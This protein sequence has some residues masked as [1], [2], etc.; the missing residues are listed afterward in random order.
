MALSACATA[1]N[2]APLMQVEPVG[3]PFARALT[4]EYRYVAK[5]ERDEMSDWSDAQHFA[6]KGLRAAN[7]IPVPPDHPD[8]RDLP[9]GERDRAV[10]KREVLLDLYDDGARRKHPERAARAQGRYDCWLEQVEENHQP[11]DIAACREQFQVALMAL[12]TAMRPQVQ[13]SDYAGPSRVRLY[14]RFDEAGITK[15]AAAKLDDLA[16]RTADLPRVRFGATGHAD[17]AGPPGY[18]MDLS[19]R[20]ARRVREA[21]AA[22]GVARDAISVAARGERDPA[23]ATPDG[24]RA[25]A[26]RRVVVTV[27]PG[28]G[29]D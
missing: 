18:N 19:G 11:A 13:T 6:A 7:G 26:N 27:R 25:R 10:E 3:G 23:V 20:R 17:R 15:R 12:Q 21:L 1:T 16:R 28:A 24:V 14:F 29:D 5:Y 9:S 8:T 4:L 22:R 2:V